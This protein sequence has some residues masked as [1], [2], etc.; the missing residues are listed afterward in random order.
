MRK[1][2]IPRLNCKKKY[3]GRLPSRPKWSK[4]G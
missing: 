2:D 1:V 4:V 3:A